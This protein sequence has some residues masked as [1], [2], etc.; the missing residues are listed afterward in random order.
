MIENTNALSKI[1]DCVSDGKLIRGILV[2][3]SAHLHGV[4]L[5]TQVYAAAA[6]IEI[7]QTS[8]LIHDD[9][10]DNDFTRR[11]KDSIFHQYMK[12][13][14][15]EKATNPL[16]FGQSMG[17]C[18][19]DIGFFLAFEL[20]SKTIEDPRILKEIVT[21][22]SVE[23]QLVGPAQ[24]I[25]TKH[26]MTTI[27]PTKDEIMDKYI[28]KTAH[29]SFSLPLTIGALFA[30]QKT[31]P[32]MR[33]FGEDLGIIF[34]LKDDELGIFGDQAKIGKPIG[35]DIRENKKTLIRHYLL[36]DATPG[37]RKKLLGIFGN[38]NLKPEDIAFVRDCIKNYLI[39]K[40]IREEIA[41]RKKSIRVTLKKMEQT[42][43][44]TSLLEDIVVYNLKRS[45]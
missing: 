32:L 45:T 33:K 20:L 10:M 29:Y 34:Q 18:V 12:D 24:M 28:Y 14:Q 13:G 9:I 5:D 35:S 31:V 25:D 41:K 38:S 27:E 43:L 19:G 8:L 26:G 36:K 2:L 40:Q 7:F 11:N 15:K 1:D 22:T 6:A 37:D 3:L 39:L 17:L 16:L 44:D 4:K 23:L 42:G 30:T 21:I